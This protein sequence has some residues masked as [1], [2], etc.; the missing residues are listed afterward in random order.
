[1]TNFK[2]RHIAG[3]SFAVLCFSLLVGCSQSGN[4]VPYYKYGQGRGSGA[5]SLGMHSFRSG[6]TLWSVANAYHVDLRDMLDVNKLSA[7]YHISVGQRLMIPSPHTYRIQKG[8]TIY[9]V[10]R[11]FDTSTTELVRLNGL[12]SPYTMAVGQML[13][14]P[15]RHV[16]SG[17]VMKSF[18]VATVPVLPPV[19]TKPT[20]GAIITREELPPTSLPSSSV[21]ETS[22]EVAS[23]TDGEMVKEPDVI[24]ESPQSRSG[25]GFLKPVNGKIISGFGEKPDGLHNDGV[26]IKAARGDAVRS[27]ENG[28]V[29]YN[30]NQIEGYG[31]MVLIR[32]ADGYMTAYAHMDKALVKKGDRVKR[33]QAI[34]TVGSTGHVDTPQLHFEIRKGK[35]AV[36][37]TPYIA[38]A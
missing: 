8:D 4:H 27:A 16:A 34:G 30:G 6:E 2:L 15:S 25:H 37:P 12:K 21:P 14:L 19:V 18:P 28:V 20:T 5:G 22:V 33:G 3:T 24:I 32:H 23:K 38:K 26:N 10:S 7:P 35:D 13:R 17:P 1:M 11:M 29:V 36:D 31:N 9:R